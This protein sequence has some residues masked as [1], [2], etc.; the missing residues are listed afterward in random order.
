MSDRKPPVRP[1][2]DVDSEALDSDRR[3]RVG[4]LTQFRARFN[5]DRVRVERQR[6][7][8]KF[9]AGTSDTGPAVPIY[10]GQLEEAIELYRML[11]A[12]F[13]DAVSRE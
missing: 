8:H 3:V 11:D 10:S 9:G 2:V 6:R 7:R 1:D 12:L 5:G 4:H 13:G